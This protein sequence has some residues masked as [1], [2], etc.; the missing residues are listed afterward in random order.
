M[1][2]PTDGLLVWEINDSANAN[3]TNGG[4]YYNDGTAGAVDKSQGAAIVRN[5]LVIG[6]TTTQVTSAGTPF[7]ASDVNN[8]INITGGA[9]FTTG[10]RRIVSVTAGV[11]T[12]SSSAGTASSTGGT[13]RLGGPM[14]TPG[15]CA[16]AI[17]AISA[18]NGFVWITGTHTVTVVTLNVANGR[19]LF[20]TGFTVRGYHAT[21][22]DNVLSATMLP[23]IQRTY[24]DSPAVLSFAN[25]SNTMLI[26]VRLDGTSGEAFG[27]AV[28]GQCIGCWLTGTNQISVS[29]TRFRQ[30]VLVA[31]FLIYTSGNSL[32]DNCYLSSGY[33]FEVFGHYNNSICIT[34]N[35]FGNGSNLSENMFATNCVFIAPNTVYAITNNKSVSFSR[36]LFYSTNAIGTVAGYSLNPVKAY[37]HQ[38]AYN[39][40]PTN[41]ANIEGTL[42][43][44]DPFINR[45][46]GDFRLTSA[47]YATL[48]ATTNVPGLTNSTFPR[49]IGAV[50]A[51]PGAS[52]MPMIGSRIGKAA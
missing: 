47:L 45:A 10:R 22:G 46:G 31:G 24:N 28:V 29:D 42:Y 20:P 4:A 32:F 49:T 51:T 36:C 16:A 1:A 26:G 50:P 3:D 27:N 25:N 9:G 8:L 18:Q 41:V 21:R 15:L 40:A 30:C 39:V 44:G 7:D 34:S 13:S 52:G 5:D 6:A 14:R 38:C 12:L 19:A 11:A 17:T 2:Y 33:N 35:A 43:S 48:A 23:L 37:M